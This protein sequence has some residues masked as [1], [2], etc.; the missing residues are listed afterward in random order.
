MM[1]T[2]R[3]RHD[4]GT[5]MVRLRGGAAWLVVCGL[6]TAGI[7]YGRLEPW[8]LE[9][10]FFLG[11]PLG[12][13]F[14][15]FWAAPTLVLQGRLAALF[16]VDAYNAF[17]RTTFD[18]RDDWMVFSYPP[19][20]LMFLAPFALMPFA[21]SL[22]VWTGLNLAALAATARVLGASRG[23][24]AVAALSPAAVVAA[25]YGH[26]GGALAL[27]ATVA[28][29]LA[30]ARPVL[31]GTLIA[32]CGAKPQF[33]VMLAGIL[34][35]AGRWRCVLWSAPFGAA[36]LAASLAV[37]GFEAW[38]GFLEW[39]VPFHRQ[40]LA[41][42]QLGYFFHTI[43]LYSAARAAALPAIA[44]PVQAAFGLAAVALAVLALRRHGPTPHVVAVVLLAC[45]LAL[46]YG[47]HYD[48]AIAAPAL[49]VALLGRERDPSGV[50]RP[51]PLV[52][53]ALWLTPVFVLPLALHDLPVLPPL[54]AAGFLGL[55][56]PAA[57]RRSPPELGRNGLF[58]LRPLY[59]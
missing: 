29:R 9:D 12:R 54:V 44:G 22:A 36:L 28:L 14:A 24:A 47:S 5:A 27:A 55:A 59:G 46:S 7:L 52:A 15:N 42:H 40:L 4:D 53:A 39:T 23:V 58:T 20:T 41:E 2:G 30:E 56:L 49:A 38:R 51:G 6:V 25:I 21:V 17:L 33:A 3:Y 18:H 16:D 10:N 37:F 1:R 11:A 35:L 26:F 48:L 19:S 31:A 57:L 45:V 43:T 8:N 32:L 34:L 13:D 50:P